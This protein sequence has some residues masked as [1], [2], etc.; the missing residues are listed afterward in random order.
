MTYMLILGLLVCI[1]IRFRPS[2]TRGIS[3]ITTSF[4][5]LDLDL[6][7]SDHGRGLDFRVG[8][9]PPLCLLLHYLTFH[10]SILWLVPASIFH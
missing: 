8:V 2:I 9:V 5:L 4:C 1:A 7:D 6:S 10:L 3:I